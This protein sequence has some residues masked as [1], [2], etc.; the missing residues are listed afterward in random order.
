MAEVMEKPFWLE[1]EISFEDRDSI[2]HRWAYD[3]EK[4]AIFKVSNQ[5]LAHRL[6]L[7]KA[8]EIADEPRDLRGWC[9]TIKEIR[10][11]RYDTEPE[12]VEDLSDKL[13]KWIQLRIRRE[14]I[15]LEPQ[16]KG[17]VKSIKGSIPF[18][19]L[20][21]IFILEEDKDKDIKGRIGYSMT[22][23]LDIAR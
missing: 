6:V 17:F 10:M 5:D 12:I 1:S 21:A 3:T 19:G 16:I 4:K 20:S 13:Q 7:D 15:G 22:F 11:S 18:S 2:V 14:F 23:D 8:Y 9:S